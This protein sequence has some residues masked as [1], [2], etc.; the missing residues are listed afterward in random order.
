MIRGGAN[1]SLRR[2]RPCYEGVC[3]ARDLVNEPANILGTLEFAAKA[4]ALDVARRQS[5]DA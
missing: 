5:R 3:L 2:A 4:T 1:E